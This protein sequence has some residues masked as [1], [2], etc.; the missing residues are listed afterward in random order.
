MARPTNTPKTSK[1]AK[2]KAASRKAR[3]EAAP[4]TADL[5]ARL[6]DAALALAAERPWDEVTLAEIA[7]RAGVALADLHPRFASRGRILS[8]FARRID[9]E[10]LRGDEAELAGERARDRLFDAIMRRFDLLAPHK[11]A[12]RSITASTMRD[13]L[14]A[15]GQVPALDRSMAWTLEA[16]GISAGGWRGRL[17]VRALGATYLAVLRVWLDDG[18][19]QAR[20]MAELD[21]RL[22][23]LDSMAERFGWAPATAHAG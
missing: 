23:R 12:L 9:A 4:E 18:P 22:A 19:D 13:P 16:A 10:M 2:P 20:T 3:P 14:A 15:L 1:A 6:V 21:R 11:D 5:E 8:A 7:A 17:K